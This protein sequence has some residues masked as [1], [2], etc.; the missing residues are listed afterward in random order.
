MAVFFRFPYLV[1]LRRS[2]TR[3]HFCGAAIVN[4]RWILS[5]AHCI[6]G[7]NINRPDE[8]VNVVGTISLTS[9]EQGDWY[10]TKQ[11]IFHPEWKEVLNRHE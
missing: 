2:T 4:A 6:A 3:G 8:F 9:T 11:F 10:E 5:A 1:S 7:S